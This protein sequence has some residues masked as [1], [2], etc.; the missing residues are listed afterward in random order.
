MNPEEIV[1]L[2][3]ALLTLNECVKKL[4]ERISE[5]EKYVQELPTPEKIYYK[6]PGTNEYLNIKGNYDQ[7]YRRI[8]ALENG[9]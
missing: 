3:E 7:I 1:S 4:S 6:P 8:E 2:N 5:I 9:M